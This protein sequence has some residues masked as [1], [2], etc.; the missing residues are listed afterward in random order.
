[1]IANKYPTTEFWAM[2]DAIPT[3]CWHVVGVRN[4]KADWKNIVATYAVGDYDAA[5]ADAERRT[6]MLALVSF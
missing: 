6:K 3:H 5:W 2:P 4:G 1:M